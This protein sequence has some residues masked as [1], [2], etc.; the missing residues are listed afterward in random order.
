MKYKFLD[1]KNLVSSLILEFF[2]KIFSKQYRDFK[3]EQIIREKLKIPTLTRNEIMDYLQHLNKIFNTNYQYNITK[4]NDQVF[5]I[6]LK[7]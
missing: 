1:Q 7:K 2:K 5:Q 4:E 3:N 6:G